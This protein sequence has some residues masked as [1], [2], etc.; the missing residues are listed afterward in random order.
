MKQVRIEVNKVKSNPFKKFINGGKLDQ[1][2]IN[3]LIEGYKQTT[4][5]ENLCARENK[6]KQ[7]ELVY[8]HHRLEAVKRVYGKTHKIFL[9]IYSYKEFSD[10]QMLLDMVRENMTQRGEDYRDMAD[11]IMLAKKWLEGS[12]SSGKQVYTTKKGGYHTHKVQEIGARQVA[13]FLSKQG[14]A[15]SHA[16]VEKY[17]S[18]EEKLHP[19]LKGKVAKGTRAGRLEEESIGFEIA[20]EISKFDKKEQ[21]MLSKE[22]EKAEVNKDKAKKLLSEYKESSEELKQK[23]KRGEINLVDIPIEKLK[24]EVKKKAEEQIEL[25]KGKIRVVHYKKF[26]REAGNQVGHTN[27]TILQTCAYLSGL[28]ESGVLY[29]L[30]WKVMYDILESATTYGKR[31]VEFAGKIRGGI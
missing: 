26:L 1:D 23:L 21:K 11:C 28:E 17:I 6:T 12:L 5:H 2:I 24:E 22:I 19:D 30:N 15:I 4:F 13:E 25:D 18:I 29:D 27:T 14:K 3:K 10:E 20:S 31:Y 7:I 16:Q 9:R 8:G